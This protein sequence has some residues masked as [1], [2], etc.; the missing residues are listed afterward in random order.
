MELA[1]QSRCGILLVAAALF[2]PGV[3]NG[4]IPGLKQATPAN[5]VKV[6]D[7]DPLGR[8]T[9]HGCLV[10]F[11][12]ASERGEYSKAAEYLDMK[13]S[14][15]TLEVARQ[16]RIVLDAGRGTDLEALSRQPEGDLN[17]GLPPNS[18]KAATIQTPTHKLEI[19]LQRVQR[20][21][22]P[23]YWLVSSQTLRQVPA[24]S[25][26]LEEEGIGK[27]LPSRLREVRIF[28]LP[29]YRWLGTLLGLAVAWAFAYVGG[30]LLVPLLRSLLRRFQAHSDDRP[31][32]T[33]VAPLRVILLAAGFRVL[34]MV[35]ATALSRQFWVSSSQ[36]IALFGVAWLAI[37][38]SNIAAERATQTLTRRQLTGKVATFTLLHRLF[39]IGV[40]ILAAVVLVWASGGDVTTIMAGVGLGGIAIA[41]AAQKTLEN[42]FGGVAL[43][44][45]EPIRVG[46]FC[47]FADKLGTVEDIGLRSTR[48]RTLDRTILSIPNGQLSNMTLENFALRDRFL[49][50]HRLGLR[51]QTA[52][53]QL[54]SILAEIRHLLQ[55]HPVV[56]REDMRVRLIQFGDSAFLVEVF[57]YLLGSD[58]LH[59]LEIQEELLLGI[60]DVI[61]A[62]GSGFA[63]PSQTLYMTRDQETDRVAIEEAEA[64]MK[65][66][67][68]DSAAIF[69]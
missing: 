35:S 60:M 19:V 67:R 62:G 29:L 15:E 24:A 68:A 41:L 58:Y 44:S 16:L 17:D 59:Y 14:T 37:R 22:V 21:G 5:P 23:P 13:P 39:K 46:D 32:P 38:A 40:I 30:R 27:L 7:S 52:P 65:V 26:E 11:L 45:D 56:D 8:D 36:A 4:Q 18:E 1:P 53:G 69:R 64:R 49:F 48:I 31:V 63:Y 33:L 47:R 20:S 57:A 66:K 6:E 3:V 50:N 25:E 34:S 2:A 61:V 10:G 42:F 12:R 51:Y 9:P 28:S 54:R 55:G 43:I